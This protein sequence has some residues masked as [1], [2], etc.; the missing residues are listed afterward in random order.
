M[1][2]YRPR[3]FQWHL[4]AVQAV[5]IIIA[6]LAGEWGIAAMLAIP[7][8]ANYLANRGQ[9]GLRIGPDGLD[10]PGMKI[11]WSNIAGIAP[12]RRPFWWTETLLLKQPITYPWWLSPFKFD[13]VSFA[14]YELNWRQ[15]RIGQDVA[16]WAPHLME[17]RD[18]ANA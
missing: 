9:I 5:A 17:K 12:P 6:V 13:R 15:G 10:F 18:R 4:V 16:R 1:S 2:E 7:T 3:A 11:P 14:R 8:G